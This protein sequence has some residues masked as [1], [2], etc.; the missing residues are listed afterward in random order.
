[1]EPNRKYYTILDFSRTKREQIQYNIKEDEDLFKERY[2]VTRK[3]SSKNKDEIK[4]GDR[5]D[6]KEYYILVVR[7]TSVD[8]KYKRVRVRLIQSDYVVR[9]RFNVRV[10]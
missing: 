5:L 2:I 6:I 9:P 1:M 10:M 4:D 3:K 8:G 7:P